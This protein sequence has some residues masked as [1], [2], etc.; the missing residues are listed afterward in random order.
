MNH[1]SLALKLNGHRL[2]VTLLG[3]LEADVMEVLWRRGP[4]AA[5][6]VT[7]AM[8]PGTRRAPST[9][10]TTL[11]RLADKGFVARRN[12][13]SPRIYT[14]ALGRPEYAAAAARTVTDWLLEHFG[15]LFVECMLDRIERDPCLRASFAALYERGRRA[16]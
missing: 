14:A 4:M 2:P 12:G 16:A 15:D 8:D 3:P 6:D 7:D 1:H 13:D 9:I 5:R 11:E 10:T